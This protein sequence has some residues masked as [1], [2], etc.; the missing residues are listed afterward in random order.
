M[1]D[2][3]FLQWGF[4]LALSCGAAWGGVKYGLGSQEKKLTKQEADI[5][6]LRIEIGTMASRG[7][8]E[9]IKLSFT[10]DLDKLERTVNSTCREKQAT[11]LQLQRNEDSE[12]AKKLDQLFK[13]MDELEVKRELQK[14][15]RNR[16][17]NNLALKIAV[18]DNTIKE[19]SVAR[20]KENG[21]PL[22]TQNVIDNASDGG[23]L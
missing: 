4:M 22:S 8:V 14:D 12:T 21:K 10:S 2:N 19:R 20:R 23:F 15:E 11:C 6:R 9:R 16:I 1:V 3:G 13:K 7:E 18:L 17:I 5:D